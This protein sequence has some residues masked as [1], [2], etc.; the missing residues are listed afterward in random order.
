M[1][2]GIVVLNFNGKADTIECVKSLLQLKHDGVTLMPIIVDNASSDDSVKEFKQQFPQVTVLVNGENLGFSEGNN[3]GIRYLL[4]KGAEYI[5][6]LNNDT[7]LDQNCVRELLHQAQALPKCGILGPKIYFAPRHEY[8]NDRYKKDELGRVIWYAG[9]LVD[10]ATTIASH[11]GVDAVDVGQFDE[12]VKTVFV[13]G[14]AMFVSIK[15]FETVGLFDP[16]LYL[17]YEDLDL[18]MRAQKKGFEI[19]YVPSARLWHKNA[20][21]SEG[22]GS[23][24]QEYYMTRNRLLVGLRFAP[25]KTKLALFRQAASLLVKGTKVQRQAV[26]DFLRKRYGKRI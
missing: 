19:Y 7:Y 18:C 5:L 6:I 11:R 25:W 26:G 16:K 3:V 4:K 22:V 8:H 23:T 13:S 2:I 20:Q 1:T 12:V 17:Y 21:S 10:W 15:V 9:G 24:L 14:C